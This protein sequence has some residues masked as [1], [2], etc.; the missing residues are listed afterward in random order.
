MSKYDNFW[1]LFLLYV[2]GGLVG[3][4]IGFVIFPTSSDTNFFWMFVWIFAL[5]LLFAGIFLISRPS[6]TTWR[7]II[8]TVDGSVFILGSGLSWSDAKV[9]RDNTVKL[10]DSKKESMVS[11]RCIYSDGVYG[12]RNFVKSNIIHIGWLEDD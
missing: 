4:L 10:F 11:V 5:A 9:L 12:V 6:V 3:L 7:V 1:S 2:F 8:A